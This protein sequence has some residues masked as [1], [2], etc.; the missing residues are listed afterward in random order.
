MVDSTYR[1]LAWLSVPD[2]IRCDRS[3]LKLGLL[4]LREFKVSL[5]LKRTY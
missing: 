4:I 2:P 5:L 3:L 1:M